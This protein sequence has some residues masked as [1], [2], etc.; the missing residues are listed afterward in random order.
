MKPWFNTGRSGWRLVLIAA[1]AFVLQMG[2][3]R[4]AQYGAHARKQ[5]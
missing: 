1:L 4:F 3:I 5:I 2:S